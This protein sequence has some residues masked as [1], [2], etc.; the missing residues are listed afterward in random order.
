[1][2]LREWL[3]ATLEAVL[4]PLEH[5][6]PVPL[7]P[8]QELGARRL[9]AILRNV[10]GALLL[11]DVGMGKSFTAATVLRSLAAAGVSGAVLAPRHLVD[12]WRRT[13]A[14][15]GVDA[16]VGSHDAAGDFPPGEGATRLLVV[17]EAHRFRNPA[18]RRYERLAR[19]SVGRALLL[20]TATPLCNRLEELRVLV[21]LAVSDDALK[22]WGIPSIDFCFESSRLAAVREILAGISIRRS[23]S[24]ENLSFP[25]GIRRVVRFDLGAGAEDLAAGIRELQVPLLAQG[26]GPELLRRHLWRRY[27]SSPEAF[28]ESMQRQ[29]R[30]YRRARE[31]L[32]AGFDLTRRDFAMLFDSEEDFYQELLFPQIFLEAK[33]GDPGPID[34]ELTRIDQLVT[35]SRKGEPDKPAAL[36]R[37]LEQMFLRPA[38][39][40]TCAVAT[41]ELVRCALSRSLRAGMASSR[42]ASDASGDPSTLDRLLQE[43]RARRLDALVLTDLAAE[44]LDVQAAAS[45]VH[46]D[47]PWTAVKVRQRSGRAIRI[48][49][50]RTEV[51]LIFF[52]P[53]R[54]ARQGPIRAVS[55]KRRLADAVLAADPIP[56]RRSNGAP[57]IPGPVRAGDVVAA[58]V[59]GV[60][61]LL[62]GGTRT[63]DPTA[64]ASACDLEI[65]GGAGDGGA[66]FSD[67]ARTPPRVSGR[68]P[69]HSVIASAI[70]KRSPFDSGLERIL[71][72]RFRSG[73][74]IA[75]GEA[76]RAQNFTRIDEITHAEE[77]HA[78]EGR[79]NR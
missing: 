66:G 39:V 38:L 21:R 1:M 44:G 55:R 7:Y 4:P 48:G 76:D 41:A 47:L 51:P 40:F 25:A 49:Q 57:V 78:R 43:F 36:T 42:L 72:S 50:V 54:Q 11:D 26:Q 45:I 60:I 27:E 79:R 46:Y 56:A 52:L 29:A 8:H 67:A 77:S 19:A 37:L 14:R 22:R 74:E 68:E 3:S 35:L 17:D 23:P 58:V 31:K 15:F 63:L 12:S 24:G 13:L 70:R 5:P 34:E 69:F 16:D 62:V 59:D 73:V 53:E 18:T 33:G 9:V 64:I 65:V 6:P 10:G 30:F 75:L 2:L 32:L 61:C 71:R 20:V 28:R